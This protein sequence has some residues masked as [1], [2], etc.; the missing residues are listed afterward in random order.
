[1]L[2]FRALLKDSPM[3]SGVFVLA[4][5]FDFPSPPLLVEHLVDKRSS[6]SAFCLEKNAFCWCAELAACLTSPHGDV[7][8]SSGRGAEASTSSFHFIFPTKQQHNCILHPSST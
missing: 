7:R 2:T 1:M 3:Y 5:P 6:V 8:V 4:E